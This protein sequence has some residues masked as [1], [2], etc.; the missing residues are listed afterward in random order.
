M[1]DDIVIANDDV[2][3][4]YYTLLS[5]HL[6][7]G[8]SLHKSIASK[9]GLMEFT[10]RYYHGLNGE[11]SP[12]SPRILAIAVRKPLFLPQLFALCISRGW[13]ASVDQCVV[14]YLHAAT[15]FRV[16]P[17]VITAGVV[18][19]LKPELIK[20]LSG[21]PWVKYPEGLLTYS[22]VYPPVGQ[23]MVHW[24]KANWASVK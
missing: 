2:A 17:E 19:L 9:T 3:A 21:S 24:T 10:K 7:V 14:N 16:L 11:L 23:V 20:G 12:I 5:Q 6:G 1:G 22:L 15:F 18:L 13:F 8:I 4:C